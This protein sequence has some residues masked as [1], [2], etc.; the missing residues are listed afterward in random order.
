MAA[1]GIGRSNW[2]RMALAAGVALVALCHGMDAA[3]AQSLSD[4]L[5]TAYQ[6]NPQ[7]LGERAQLRATDENVPQA[8]SGWRPTVSLSGQGGIQHSETNSAISSGRNFDAN[9]NPITH[10]G[11][12]DNTSSYGVTVTQNLFSGGQTTAQTAQALN[13]VRAERANLQAI[14]QTVLVAAATDYV[15][16][17]E[18]QAA[19]ELNINNEQVFRRELEYTRDRFEVGEVT[20]TD[21]AQAEASL[22]QAIAARQQAAAA[23]QVARATYQQDIG[24]VPGRLLPPRVVI[25]LPTSQD[26]AVSMAMTGDPS[27][28]SAQFTQA[29]A[30]DNIRVVRSQL[31]PHI[32]LNATAQR[33]NDSSFNGSETTSESVV[34]Q[35]NVP[36]YEGGSVYS[37][38]RQAQQTVTVDRNKLDQARRAAM[39]AAASAWEQM[40]EAQANITSFR[41]QIE[42]NAIALQGVQQEAAVGE[43]TVL[44]ILN[45]EQ[46]LFQSRVSLI[47]AQHDELVAKF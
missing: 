21:V 27:V 43:R 31:L 39:Q 33:S 41:T 15:T 10:S 32:S 9:G 44:D 45:A 35:M 25:A 29:A 38:S 3:Q 28:V 26:E 34:A 14:E 24:E 36:L 37:Q 20:R 18:D 22:A 4:A 8:L 12:R 7:L 13:Q 40:R 30:E 17:L 5:A 11:T 42:A 2:R 19:L 47:Q 1:R 6:N 23:L 16:V 46:T